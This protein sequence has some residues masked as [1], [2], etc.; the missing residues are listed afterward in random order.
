M[1]QVYYNV[2]FVH[3]RGQWQKQ[4]VTF[5]IFQRILRPSFKVGGKSLIN[6]YIGLYEVPAELNFE[7]ETSEILSS[8]QAHF[9]MCLAREGLFL[10]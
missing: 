6:S 8:S 7:G 3:F 5:K 4:C 1:L 9:L 2:L 10:S